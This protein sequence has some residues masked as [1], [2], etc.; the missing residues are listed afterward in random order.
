GFN[1]ENGYKN[2]PEK[3]KPLIAVLV[4]TA[5]N[6]CSRISLTAAAACLSILND[7]AGNDY[8]AA[9]LILR[10]QC[11]DDNYT[12]K[13]D[14]NLDVFEDVIRMLKYEKDGHNSEAAEFLKKLGDVENHPYEYV[15]GDIRY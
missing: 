6:H 12:P 2:L 9:R 7:I 1:A 11:A 10:S 5:F 8:D 15:L 3:D 13:Q 4:F 14:A